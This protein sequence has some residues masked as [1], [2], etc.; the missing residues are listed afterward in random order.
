[1][2]KRCVGF[3][4]GDR[5][6]SMTLLAGNAVKKAVS[7]DLPDNLVS[8]GEVVSMDALADLIREAAKENGFP[9]SDAALILPSSQVYIRNITTPAMT[10]KQFRYSL[11][12]EFSDY[13]T[14]EKGRY[15][16]D[17]AITGIRYTEEDEAVEAQKKQEPV[18]VEMDAL[19]CCTLRSGIEAYRSM[20]RRAGFRLKTAVPEEFAL[21]R[22]LT[23]ETEASSPFC[24]CIV[25]IGYRQT[26]LYFFIENR[27]VFKR[28]VNIGTMD[29]EERL[30]EIQ[31]LDLQLAHSR[32]ETN[33]E[34]ILDGAEFESIYSNLSVEVMKA[35]NFFN[36]NNRDKELG[37][38][39]ICGG[40]LASEYFSRYIAD[41]VEVYVELVDGLIQNREQSIERPWDHLI[42]YCAALCGKGGDR[43]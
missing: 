14:E 22:V 6:V 29:L 27:Y 1:M 12:Y 19:A 5:S 35:I 41:L 43:K 31:D 24:C 15:V 30:T 10:D 36:Y 28:T 34:H 39:Y 18:P 26:G 33:Y 7:V 11:P 13:L 3:N 21:S 40:G 37:A 16:Y 2:A 20:F 8:G 9:K 17:Y 42:S 25:S 4:I 23:T 38:V 32:V